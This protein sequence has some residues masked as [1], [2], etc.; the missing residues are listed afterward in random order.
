M[1]VKSSCSSGR[2]APSSPAPR[3]GQVFCPSQAGE[4]EPLGSQGSAGLNC[5]L[6]RGCVIVSPPGFYFV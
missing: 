6:S 4:R 1:T 2:G 5:S 3:R